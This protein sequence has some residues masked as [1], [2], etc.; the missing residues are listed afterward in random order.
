MAGGAQAADRLVTSTAD[1][2]GTGTFRNIMTNLEDGDVI[3]FDDSLTGDTIK[4]QGTSVL[5]AFGNLTKLKDK[6]LTVFGNG[7]TIAGGWGFFGSLNNNMK[8][9]QMED[10]HFV[11]PS[12]TNIFIHAQ[13]GH[14]QNCTFSVTEAEE[15][16][17]FHNTVSI[18]GESLVFR[19]CAFISTEGS[20]HMLSLGGNATKKSFVSCTFVKPAG[21]NDI[22]FSGMLTGP[23]NS[24]FNFSGGSCELTNCVVMD[25]SSGKS[26]FPNSSTITSRGYNVVLQ[27]SNAP[28][29]ALPMV[30]GAVGDT[31]LPQDATP[32]PLR[33]HEGVYRVPLASPAY[34]RLS[35]QAVLETNDALK[36]LLPFPEHD[37]AGNFI[38]Y[39]CKT[40]SGAWQTVYLETGEYELPKECDATAATDI[41]LIL[42]EETIYTE[43]TYTLAAVTEPPDASQAVSWESS[44]TEVATI[45]ANGKLTPLKVGTTTI[46]VTSVGTP[47]VKA[48]AEIEVVAYIHVASLELPESLDFYNYFANSKRLSYRV[49]PEDALNPKINWTVD[50]P[51]GLLDVNT[52]FLASQNQV[53]ITFKESAMTLEL[54]R[55]TATATLTGTTE[56]GSLSKTCTINIGTGDFTEGVILVNEGNY[57]T[58]SGSLHY[59]H[60]DGRWEEM[61]WGGGTTGQFGTIYKEHFFYIA[62]Q[63]RD[64]SVVDAHTLN[65]GIHAGRNLIQDGDPRAF[66]GVDEHTGYLSSSNGIYIID[67]DFEPDADVAH[68][69]LIAGTGG[70]GFEDGDNP[71]DPNSGLYSGQTG[72]MVRAGNYAFALH[73]TKGLLVIDPVE[74]KVLQSIEGYPFNGLVLAGDG[75]LWSGTGGD[76]L[77]C[78]DPWTLELAEIAMPLPAGA[79]GPTATAWG[80]WR[81]E[82]LMAD[83]LGKGLYWGAGGADNVRFGPA[84]FYRYDIDEGTVNTMLDLTAYD[85]DRW[86]SYGP[87][88]GI[89]PVTGEPYVAVYTGNGNKDYRVLRIDPATATVTE[90]YPMSEQYWFPS[91]FVFPDV[92]AP[93]LDASFP[94]SVTLNASHPFDTLALR[95]LVSDADNMDAA[96]VKTVAAIGDPALVEAFIRHDSLFIAP[97]KDLAEADET[98]LTLKFNSN[99]KVITKDLSVKVEPGAIAHPV[100]GVTLSRTASTLAVGQT[101]QLT[102]TVAPDDADNKA[103]TWTSDNPLIASVDENGLVTA[104][105]APSTAR[106]TVTTQEGNHTAVCT[107]TTRPTG[108]GTVVNPFELTYHTLSMDPDQTMTLSLTAPQHFNVTWSS[109]NTSVATVSGNGTVR[110]IAAGMALITARDVAQGKS[111]ICLV[112]V[113]AASTPPRPTERL[114]LNTSQLSLLRGETTRLTATLSDGLTGRAITWSTSNPG[115]ADVTADGTVIALLPGSCMIRAAVDAYEASCLVTVSDYNDQVSVGNVTASDASVTIPTDPQATYFLVHLYRKT[116]LIF[117]PQYTLKVTPD[118][119]VTL[120]RSQPGTLSVPLS[121]LEAGV[122][123]ITEVEVVRETNGHADVIRTET[124]VFTTPS[125]ATGTETASSSAQARVWYSGGTLRLAN[126]AEHT[127]HLFNLSGQAVAVFRIA[128]D[129]ESRRSDLPAGVYIVSAEKAESRK[130]FRIVIP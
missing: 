118:G 111:D 20:G 45:D 50:D 95:P 94:V 80:A 61:V 29:S 12:N 109:S 104:H 8:S 11:N 10:L 75:N 31:I 52:T 18:K 22:Y 43:R 21:V 60:P 68:K 6:T 23:E 121:Y 9:L 14:I 120:L 98:T 13:S 70:E 36:E 64:L 16:R 72:T 103:I 2:G 54:Y 38:D 4:L 79:Q 69:G 83:P 57:A 115:V 32:N 39:T 17:Y 90:E 105:L 129:D 112:T 5:Y 48:T 55:T 40:H 114:T 47:S 26:T 81:I 101:L 77:L 87:T 73:Q 58:M 91:A 100:T 106:I 67:L 71:A 65:T 62:K 37:P 110:S 42:P 126:L 88:Y 93:R 85:N 59:L 46:T 63:G 84:W 97:L 51:D 124:T 92:E 41:K 125:A 53:M 24:L 99:G 78:I 19:G 117:E 86:R 30:A 56:D 33:L 128:T 82:S 7:V 49:L 44:D 122:S 108:S 89:H 76:K 3:R 113:N 1:D 35:S 28:L 119:R 27:G 66:A 34:R 74:H 25:N 127:V 15:D 116:G 107:V 102:A 123:Y 130:I 96:I